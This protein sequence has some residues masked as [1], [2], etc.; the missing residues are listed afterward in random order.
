MTEHFTICPILDENNLSFKYND[1]NEEIML[2]FKQT[3]YPQAEHK[4]TDEN[5]HW[6]MELH[7]NDEMTA[8]VECKVRTQNLNELHWDDLMVDT[9]KIEHVR[10][11]AEA[12]GV[13][14]YFIS[15]FIKHDILFIVK[16]SNKG[17]QTGIKIKN[18]RK[19]LPKDNYSG[20]SE[21][22][23]ISYI[24]IY[25]DNV[26]MIGDVLYFSRFCKGVA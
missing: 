8:I 23:D 6:D 7:E 11:K 26:N 25:Q 15:Y 20:R 16:F 9:A 4:F 1:E 3:Y 24:P 21:Y 12:E 17:K 13:D 19:K 2:F 10:A 14:A 5:C 22:T 18:Y